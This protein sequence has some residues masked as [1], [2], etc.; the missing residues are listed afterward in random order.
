MENNITCDRRSLNV[1]LQYFAAFFSTALVTIL[2]AETA[3]T[4]EAVVAVVA[5]ADE[6][7]EEEV[8]FNFNKLL[9]FPLLLL[10]LLLTD[11]VSLEL[12]FAGTWTSDSSITI[13][14]FFNGADAAVT[15]IWGADLS[16]GPFFL[17]AKSDI[18]IL[19]KVD[20]DLIKVLLRLSASAMYPSM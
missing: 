13:F 8:V 4:A 16:G 19:R 2:D 11:K 17:G 12:D 18:L 1:S 10:L 6:D 15:V 20:K 3:E 9:P 5:L 14:C 7:E